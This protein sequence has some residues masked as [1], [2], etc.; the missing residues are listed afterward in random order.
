MISRFPSAPQR[1]QLFFEV[2]TTTESSR[3]Q[4]KALQR[5]RRAACTSWS[6]LVTAII[7]ELHS[8][9]VQMQA[10]VVQPDPIQDF[11]IQDMRFGIH[12]Q[13]AM[14]ESQKAESKNLQSE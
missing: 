6:A 14:I 10:Y 5:R 7:R 1:G 4:R 11:A 3:R 2:M 12:R 13:E 9:I 8:E